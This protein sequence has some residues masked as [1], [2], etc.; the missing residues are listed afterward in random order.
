MYMNGRLS[1]DY[2]LSIMLRTITIL[3]LFLLSISHASARIIFVDNSLA[4]DCASGYDYTT[5]SCGGG[6]YGAFRTIKGAADAAV[7]GDTVVLRSGTYGEQLAP[8]NS[9][10]ASA[11]I[12]YTC[13]GSEQVIITGAALTPAIYIYRKE[14]II[15][16]GI[17]VANVRRWL[18][19]LGSNHITIRSCAFAN[20][21]DAGG[22]SKTGLFFQGSDYNAVRDCIIDNSTQ[23]NLALVQSDHNLVQGN[24]ITRAAHTL[25][26]IKCGSYNVLRGNYFHNEYQ[27]IGEI[28]D[29]DGVGYGDDGF[30]KITSLDDTK[31]NV[32]ED[33]TFAYTATPVDASPY[34]GIQ[35]AGQNCIIRGNIFYHC[36]GPPIDLTLYDTEAKSNY[37]NRIYNNVFFGN[38]F[39]GIAV[40]GLD[41]PGY[42]L[43]DNICLNNV[44]YRNSF[45]RYDTRWSWYTTLDRKPVQI[46]TGRTSGVRFERNDLL[47]TVANELWIIAYGSRTSASN[48]APQPLAWWEA[49]APEM[50]KANLQADPLFADTAA[51]DFRLR[52]KS[53]LVDAGAFLTRTVSAGSGTTMPVEG[54]AWFCDGYGIA[55]LGGDTIQLQGRTDRA[56]IVAVDYTNNLLTLDR[57][58]AWG[59]GQRVGLAYN[60]AAPDIGAFEQAAPAG[61]V[62]PDG[63]A[64]DGVTLG[65][66]GDVA[67]YPNPTNGR[68]TVTLASGSAFTSRIQ[69]MDMYGELV[70]SEPRRPSAGRRDCTIDLGDLPSGCYLI[71]I[72]TDRGVV[73]KSCIR[74]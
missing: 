50:F 3:L 62:V 10:T 66:G 52:A 60:G 6:T 53:P 63:F 33:N 13:L 9:G 37:G 67:L 7:P 30:D 28:L 58:F 19:A 5:R 39:G 22:S 43:D 36:L 4:A 69:V 49:N 48:P 23:D 8:K 25:W 20:A 16:Q 72:E 31:H 2:R 51:L 70:R 29:C 34:A 44:F 71:M 41:A 64:P 45:A 15:L 40:S 68:C 32:V 57:P 42:T 55:G 56:V 18:A 11:P 65:I 46:I 21:N 59:D 27:K 17:I 14:H 1:I 74:R 35:H 24:R 61:G 38:S 47:D 26:T 54:A 73:T 12:I